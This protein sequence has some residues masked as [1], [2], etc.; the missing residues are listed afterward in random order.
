M[1]R[2]THP[3]AFRPLAVLAIAAATAVA[4][5][6]VL[7]ATSAATPAAF[8]RTVAQPAPRPPSAVVTLG[9]NTITGF[10]PAN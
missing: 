1:P 7:A 3:H 4:V 9:R 5:T 8:A 6:F 10:A 2:R